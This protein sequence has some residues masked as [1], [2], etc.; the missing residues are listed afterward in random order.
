MVN[1][2]IRTQLL[3]NQLL[4]VLLKTALEIIKYA[5]K[6]NIE[7]PYHIYDLTKD[8]QQILNQIDTPVSINKKCSICDKLNLENAEYCCYCGSS[9]IITRMRH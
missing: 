8:A 2:V 5:D 3:N 6:H 7:I 1:E 9:M 4:D